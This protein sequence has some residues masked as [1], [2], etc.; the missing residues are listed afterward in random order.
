M[1]QIFKQI[2]IIPLKRVLIHENTVDKWANAIAR[3][4]EEMGVMKNPVV[5]H[6]HEDHYVV[7][8]GMHRVAALNK[9]N[10]RDILVYE[11][12][13]FREDIKLGG[14]DGIATG[15]YKGK[16]IITRVFQK[17]K[18]YVK[19]IKRK[20]S[21]KELVRTRKALLGIKTNRGAQYCVFPKNFNSENYIDLSIE[22]LEYFEKFLDKAG[23]KIVY[24]PDTTSDDDFKL[25]KGKFLIYRPVYRKQEIVERTLKGKIFPRKTTRHIIPGRPLRVDIPLTILKEKIDLKIK[26]KLLKAHLLWCFS[27]NKVRY[28]P[29]PV[30]VF[31]D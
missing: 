15:K 1:K 16:H 10:S 13:Y 23:F 9:I 25:L 6:R 12:D 2:K 5:V 11:V 26:N 3:Y 30:Y 28:Y 29:E 20:E 14:W 24:V 17:T 19:K 31:S 8:D 21:A 22:V 18:F 27:N 7:L 4:M